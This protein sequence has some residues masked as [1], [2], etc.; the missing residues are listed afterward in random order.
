[1]PQPTSNSHSELNA[2]LNRLDQIHPASISIETLQ[3]MQA[4]I[5][6]EYSDLVARGLEY[7]QT[8][9]EALAE[10]RPEILGRVKTQSTRL[11]AEMESLEDLD[12]KLFDAMHRRIVRDN[13]T[14]RLG[15][16]TGLIALEAIVMTLIVLV[17]GLL[18]Y[19]TT[20]G[21]D[22]QRPTWL[23][24]D[25]IFIIDAVCCLIFMGE[26]FLRLSCAESKAFVWKHHWVDFVTSIPIPGEAQLARFG[27]VARLARFARVLRVM[28]FLRFLRL[29]FL[30][31][32][33][34]DKLQDVIDVKLMKRTLRWA[35]TV[36]V[37]GALLVYQIEGSSPPGSGADGDNAVSSY[38]L[39][40]W[41]SFTTVVTGGF[42]DIH[43]P[44]TASGQLLTAFLVV[45]G[46][47]LIGVFTATLTSLFLGEQSEEIERLQ[48][49]LGVRLDRLTEKIDGAEGLE[50]AT[51]GPD[52]PADT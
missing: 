34:M 9:T 27:R 45:M 14:A 6:S 25:S 31:W 21:P 23:S 18:V 52:P 16:R 17:L 39:A 11:R 32:R 37:I 44:E 33:G 13:M 10:A 38:P 46:M 1:M 7:E 24:S 3:A 4:T 30:L 41:W 22:S 29:F 5:H 40:L 20:A 49:E 26:F 50:Q 42:G 19:D 15:S 35:V 12:R 28:R 47:V 8:A 43:N 36:M 2:V 51:G 48:E